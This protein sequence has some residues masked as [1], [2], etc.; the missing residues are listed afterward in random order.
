MSA[1][2]LIEV[3]HLATSAYEI[4]HGASEINDV[5]DQ[6]QKGHYDKAAEMSQ[7]FVEEKWEDIQATASPLGKL[8]QLLWELAGLPAPSE[9]YEY[10]G[11]ACPMC[12]FNGYENYCAIYQCPLDVHQCSEGH[13]WG[14]ACY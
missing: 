7:Q 13:Q 14:P 8:P 6:V 3:V 12:A 1:S 4:Y 11:N 10:D 5:I 2:I 9:G